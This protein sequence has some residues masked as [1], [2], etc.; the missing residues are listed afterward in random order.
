MSD[1]FNQ[2]T[3]LSPQ[4]APVKVRANNMALPEVICIEKEDGSQYALDAVCLLGHPLTVEL[5][6]LQVTKRAVIKRMKPARSDTSKSNPALSTFEKRDQDVVGL[7]MALFGGWLMEKQLGRPCGVYIKSNDNT[8]LHYISDAL[9]VLISRD[10]IEVVTKGEKGK[11]PTAYRIVKID[12]IM[13]P[14]ASVFTPV[15]LIV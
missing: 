8:Q 9:R 5:E 4:L 7:L 14:L 2:A 15:K 13:E 10:I 12:E 11:K 3:G 6:P 1:L